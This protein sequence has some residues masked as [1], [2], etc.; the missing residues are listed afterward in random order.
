MNMALIGDYAVQL[1]ALRTG[2]AD[3]WMKCPWVYLSTLEETNPE[4]RRVE[5]Q[6]FGY[7]GIQ[8]RHDTWPF[9]DVNVRRALSMAIDRQALLDDLFGGYGIIDNFYYPKAW[10]PSVK[11]PLKDQPDN[12]YYEYDV[13]AAKVLLEEA[14]VP[15]GFQCECAMKADPIWIDTMSFVKDYWHDV[16]VEVE[17]K[18]HDKASDW[19]I[20][21]AKTHKHMYYAVENAATPMHGMHADFVTGGYENRAMLADPYFDATI[22]A[23]RVETNEE[24]QLAAIRELN[25]YLI[26]IMAQVPLPDYNNFRYWWPWVRNYEGEMYTQYTSSVGV[27]SIVWI[28]QDMKKEMGY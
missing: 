7:G 28:D 21:M 15:D 13:A 2:R 23:Y 16:G 25:D 19:G 12:Q 10:G 18:V 27:I 14:G 1:A 9:S 11:T 20:R 5:V 17:L 3:I 4:L 22:E 8:V 24:A 6:A 26:S